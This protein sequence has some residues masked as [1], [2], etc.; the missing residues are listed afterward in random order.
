MLAGNITKN[1][2]TESVITFD[3]VEPTHGDGLL[4]IIIIAGGALVL[5]I[6]V[7]I[8]IVCCCCKSKGQTEDQ[9]HGVD[10]ECGCVCVCA[11]WWESCCCSHTS[12]CHQHC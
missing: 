4:L 6:V 9:F 7:I 10:G 3:Y 8:V 1:V 5:L 12:H 2:F 11:S